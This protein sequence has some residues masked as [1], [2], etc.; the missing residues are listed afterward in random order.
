MDE[1][2]MKSQCNPPREKRREEKREIKGNVLM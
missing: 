1:V 2:E